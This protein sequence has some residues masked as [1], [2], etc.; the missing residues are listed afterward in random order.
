MGV[1]VA[2]MFGAY[3]PSSWGIGFAGTLAL[4][5]LIVPS[6]KSKTSVVS[7]LVATTTCVLTINLPYRLTIVCSVI[8]GVLAAVLMDWRL[9]RGGV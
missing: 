9:K 4:I 5:A 7:A 8:A 3:I 6:I 1:L 2:I